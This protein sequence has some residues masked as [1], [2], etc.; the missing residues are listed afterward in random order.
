MDETEDF[1]TIS[2][3]GRFPKRSQC[4]RF[5]KSAESHQSTFRRKASQKQRGVENEDDFYKG[6]DQEEDMHFRQLQQEY[7]LYSRD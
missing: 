6:T 1:P 3:D 5:P 2:R 7:I 4:Q